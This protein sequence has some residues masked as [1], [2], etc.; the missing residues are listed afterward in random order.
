[1]NAYR[2]ACVGEL[3]HQLQISPARLRLQQI[4]ATDYLLTLIEPDQYYPYSWVC[5]HITGYRSPV[6]QV[7]VANLRGASLTVDLL[8][9][10]PGPDAARPDP[11]DGA[12]PGGLDA[13]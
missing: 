9:P 13:G 3:A 7:D 8:Q 2:L 6:G 12:G 1:M 5:W 4:L 10:V 11:A